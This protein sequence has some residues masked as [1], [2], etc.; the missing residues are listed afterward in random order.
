M[1]DRHARVLAAFAAL[2]VLA[3]QAPAFAESGKSKKV[4]ASKDAEAEARRLFREGDRLY[5]E[6]DYEGAVTAFEKAYELSR[7]E[8]LKY[9]LANAYERLGRYEAALTALRDYLPYTKPEEQDVVR[10]RI[11]KLEKR[12]EEQRLK[13]QEAQSN[14]GSAPGSTAPAPAIAPNTPPPAADVPPGDS[15]PAPVLGYVLLGVGAVGIGAGAFFGVQA[16]GDKSDAEDA[17]ADSSDGRRCPASAQGAVDDAKSKALIADVSL[18][19]GIVAAAVGGY[20][21]LSSGAEKSASSRL[22]RVSGGN[23][24][25]EL[26]LIGTF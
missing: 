16:L 19:V 24:G 26:R 4:E 11:E 14:T 5:A 21:V 1:F 3:A 13:A 6:G 25:G 2:T 17:C 8:A 18:G 20:L 23:R 9:N 10:R 15:Q 22:L 7:K 12:V